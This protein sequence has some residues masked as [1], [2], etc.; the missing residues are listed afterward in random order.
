MMQWR[1]SWTNWSRGGKLVENMCVDLFYHLFVKKN[2]ETLFDI[3]LPGCSTIVRGT[4]RGAGSLCMKRREQNATYPL[5]RH[6][7]C[8]NFY[9]LSCCVWCLVSF[10]DNKERDASGQITSLCR[11]IIQFR[12]CTCRIALKNTRCMCI[13]YF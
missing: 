5:C 13:P 9:P 12:L 2:K 11:N 3:F 8:E 4:S 7:Y 10:N 1:R 6:M